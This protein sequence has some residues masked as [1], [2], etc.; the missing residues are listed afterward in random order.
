M[1]PKYVQKKFQKLS[2]ELYKI[3]EIK[4]FR[5]VDFFYS[6]LLVCNEILLLSLYLL[7][8][9]N[10]IINWL[11]ELVKFMWNRSLLSIVKKEKKKKKSN[12]WKVNRKQN[13]VKI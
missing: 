8:T 2:E 4:Q 13:N 7:K 9:F 12:D 11:Y 1:Q 3:Q 10:N 5:R 6:K